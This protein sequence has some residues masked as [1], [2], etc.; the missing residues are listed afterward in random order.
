M[1]GG[2][3]FSTLLS[4]LTENVAS[5][6]D[7]RRGKNRVHSM[8]DFAMS[9]FATFFTQ[10]PSFLASQKLMRQKGGRDNAQSLFGIEK[11]PTDNRIRSILDEVEPA[12]LW[13]VYRKSF[14]F[15]VEKGEVER[16]RCFED[17]LLLALDGTDYY[18]SERIHCPYCQVSD[19]KDGRRSYKHTAL[20]PALVKPRWSEVI[21]LAPEFVLPQDGHKKQDC[22][23]QAVKRWI[24]REGQ[25][26]G[27]LGVTVLGDDIY[28]C[29]PLIKRVRD[30]RMHFIFVAK[31]SS[32]KYLYEELDGLDKLKGIQSVRRRRREGKHRRFYHYRYINSVPLNGTKDSPVVNWCELSILDQEG[33]LIYRNSFVTDHP[34]NKENI[35]ILVECG[36]CRWKIE[37]EDFNTLKTKGY[38]FEH[39]F[40]HGKHYLSQT[41]L[42]L[43]ILSFLFHTALAAFDSDYAWLR[44]TLPRR[45]TFFQHV[46]AL[47][48]YHCFASWE[49]LLHFMVH[50]L[51]EGP[52]PPPEPFSLIE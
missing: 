9:A 18:Y 16:Y 34:I 46:S 33:K 1:L 26:Y 12:K 43:N 5:W 44:K 50:R 42:S 6:E 7:K 14:D 22:E 13:P 21:P 51:Q 49:V 8:H 32:H 36:R 11:I 2:S 17:T 15:L 29:G 19:H 48:Q 39:N 4:F 40:G 45:E 23:L 37:N 41:L 10:S 24:S 30:C 35:E 52:A 38:H 28:S 31:P 47:L 25:L 3:V 20:M 27:N